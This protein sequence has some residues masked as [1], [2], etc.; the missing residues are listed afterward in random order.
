LGLREGDVRK[1]QRAGLALASMLAVCG[2]ATSAQAESFTF[3]G[4][5]F[6]Q[7]STPDVIGLLGNGAN[8]GGAVFSDGVANT[9]T[10]SVGFL[11]EP[12]GNANTGFTPVPGFDPALSLGRLANAQL[13]LTQNDGSSCLFACAV[14]LPLNNDGG[15]LRHGIEVSWSGGR[16]LSNGA[17]GDFVIYESGS[18]STSP[19]HLMVRVRK[20]DGTFSE[21][22]F[23]AFDSFQ[24]YTNLPPTSEGA[25]ATVFDLSDFG[26]SD[27]E[28]IDLIQIATILSGDRWDS[29]TGEFQFDGT[30]TA[31][32]TSNGPLDPDPLYIG[33]L[34]RLNGTEVDAPSALATML[35]GLTAVGL[36][37]RRSRREA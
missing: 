27:D 34:H 37:R 14:N 12:G 19:E 30:G 4:V 20:T 17:G 26:L 31:F 2:F 15:N 9:I 6:I 10:R 29:T 35:V 25:F 28:A 22:R 7:E 21:W 8:L 5:T 24:V 1:H 32:S 13:G 36:Y 11:A 16:T 18:N 3:A 23:E 33:V